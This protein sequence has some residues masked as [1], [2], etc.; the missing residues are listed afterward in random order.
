MTTENTGKQ[1]S[2]GAPKVRAKKAVP[3]PYVKFYLADDFRSES[4]GKVTA[5]GLYPDNVIVLNTPA[6]SPEPSKDRPYGVS[7]LGLLICI[8][9]SQGTFPVS[10]SVGENEPFRKTIELKIGMSSNLVLAF[11]PLLLASL[12]F[13]KVKVTVDAT[14]HDFQFEARRGLLNIGDEVGIAPVD[15]SI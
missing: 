5:V 2:V 3:S 9:G 11:R 13:K 8:G 14:V 6:N 15:S 10:I 7:S 1:K 4:S 12:G